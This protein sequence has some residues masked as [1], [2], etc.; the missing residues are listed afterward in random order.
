MRAILINPWTKSIDEV[1]IPSKN[2][3]EAVYHQLSND[4]TGW[5]VLCYELGVL[6]LN[7]DVLLVDEEAWMKQGNHPAPAFTIGDQHRMVLG[8]G[9]LVQ[10]TPPDFGPAV[11]TVEEIKAK[12]E[13]LSA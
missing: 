9:L 11:S 8:K 3:N 13:W 5:K 10:M 2:F 4:P 12:V 7:G 1:E 6:F